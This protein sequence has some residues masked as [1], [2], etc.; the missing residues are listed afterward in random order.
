MLTLFLDI[1]NTLIYSHRHSINTPKRAAEFLNGKEQSFITEK[2]YTYLS[3]R[4]DIRIIPV[5]TR[6][7][8]QFGRIE[9]LLSELGCTIS[10]VC[11]GAILLDNGAVD[12]RWMDESLK[13]S[14]NE[15]KELPLATRWLQ[16][17]CGMEKIHTA[18]DLFVYSAT[19][20]PVSAACELSQI[21]DSQKVD[22][23]CDSRKV[24][25]IPKSLN[26]GTALQRFIRQFGVSHPIVA[27]D[28]DFDIPMLNLGEIAIIP[29]DLAHKVCNTR[30]IVVNEIQCFSDSICDCIEKLS[31]DRRYNRN[32]DAVWNN[33]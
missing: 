3:A 32:G 2:T 27:G 20:N 11:N 24:Y 13:L 16:N 28:S 10:L 23:L 8:S 30:T 19:G 29:S 14:E 5:T 17:R 22:V 7:L 6:T 1:D 26:K 25:C 12:T 18:S 9:A 31:E 15:R 4:K 21:V 33:H